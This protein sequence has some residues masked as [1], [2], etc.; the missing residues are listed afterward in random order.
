MTYQ[1]GCMTAA[2]SS[3]NCHN[4]ADTANEYHLAVRTRMVCE[5]RDMTGR[6]ICFGVEDEAKLLSTLGRYVRL[7]WSVPKMFTPP[8]QS[9][10]DLSGE[11]CRTCRI[12][13]VLDDVSDIAG[14]SYHFTG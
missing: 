11:R 8:P 5:Y 1:P 2:L 6:T 4:A 3:W 12:S 7:R 10:C 14:G 13:G 9:W